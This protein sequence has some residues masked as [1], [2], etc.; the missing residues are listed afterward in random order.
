MLDKN[1]RKAVWL[2]N[3]L[4]IDPGIIENVVE[5]YNIAYKK[6]VEIDDF[7]FRRYGNK[8]QVYNPSSQLYDFI[9]FT[10]LSDLIELNE[11]NFRVILCLFIEQI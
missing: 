11:E 9:P 7:E 6:S 2:G 5:D 4:K 1:A 3:K 10:E 8:L